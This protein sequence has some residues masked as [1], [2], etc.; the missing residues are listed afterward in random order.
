MSEEPNVLV[1]REEETD[2]HFEPVIKL[3]EQVELKTYEEDEIVRFK[4][5]AKLFRF[6]TGSS[7]WKER[8]TGDVRLLEHKETKKTRLVMRRDKTLKVCANHVIS[9]EMRL[10]PNIGSDR[11]WVWKVAADYSESPPTSETLA[12]RFANSDSGSFTCAFLILLALTCTDA[13]QFKTAFEDAQKSNIALTGG[14]P[15]VN[16]EESTE[17]EKQ[18]IGKTD[19][20]TEEPEKKEEDKKDE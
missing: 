8:G 13:A 18:R 5:R 1:P 19:E 12:I 6:D 20:K 7:E 14:A 3:T 9:A 15:E 10:Q 2:V 16:G 4:M 17:E 11:S